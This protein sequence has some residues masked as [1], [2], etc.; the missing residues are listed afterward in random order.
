MFQ[1]YK[2]RSG[3]AQSSLTINCNRLEAWSQTIDCEGLYLQ[4]EHELVDHLPLKDY[5][6]DENNGKF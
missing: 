2:V 4:E 1:H 3:Q 5:L 6:A